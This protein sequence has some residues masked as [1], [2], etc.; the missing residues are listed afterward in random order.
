VYRKLNDVKSAVAE[1]NLA[2]KARPTG[3]QLVYTR[4]QIHREAKDIPAARADFER[5]IALG[6]KAGERWL[7]SAHAELGYLKHLAGDHDGAIKEYD[8]ALKVI[9]NFSPANLYKADTRLAQRKH[10]EAGKALDAYL[11]RATPDAK[12]YTARG[13]IHAKLKEYG[14]AAQAYTRSLD[15]K[16]D[17]QV[18]NYRGWAYLQAQALL[19]ARDDF[20]AVLKTNADHADALCGRAL[21][22]ALTGEAADAVSE[23]EKALEKGEPTVTLLCNVA[24]VYVRAGQTAPGR[25]YEDRGAELLIQAAKKK[26]MAERVEFWR[27]QVE[28]DIT[29]RT[30]LRHPAVVRVA[31][32]HGW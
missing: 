3:G 31:R 25:R 5:V 16:D 11:A 20:D 32:S 23:A 22:R 12:V 9:P 17:V 2:V 29:L 7:A 30:L 15:L 19:L 26:P 28:K 6:G 13:L 18:R 4:A 1:M 8:A 21:V 14:P 27:E 24:A 10:A